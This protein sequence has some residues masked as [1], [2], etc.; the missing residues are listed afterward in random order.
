MRT[1]RD[2][3]PHGADRDKKNLLEKVFGKTSTGVVYLVSVAVLLLVLAGFV[4]SY[5]FRGGVSLLSLG[6]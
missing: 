4:A 5:L 2:G 3:R 6:G 1:R